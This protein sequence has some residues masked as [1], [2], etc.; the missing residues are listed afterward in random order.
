MQFVYS[1]S[2]HAKRSAFSAFVKMYDVLYRVYMRLVSYASPVTNSTTFF[3]ATFRCNSRDFIQ[4]RIRFF[5]VYEHNLSF[6]MISRLHAGGVLID[7]GANAGYFSVLGSKLVGEQGKVISV[8]ADPNNYSLLN[9]NLRLNNCENVEAMNVAATEDRCVV[10]IRSMDAFNS[11]RS[12]IVLQ[13]LE[14]AIGTPGLPFSD[15]VKTE[16]SRIN[17]IKVDIE[18]SEGPVL[19]QIL[20]LLNEMPN[21]LIVATEVSP[22]S[23]WCI[24]AF[25]RA[26]FRA[27][28]ISNNYKID[29]YLIRR[30]LAYCGE[31]RFISVMPVADYS[32]RHTDYVFERSLPERRSRRPTRKAGTLKLD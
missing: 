31:H 19:K 5:G 22:S 7:I 29:Y 27:F 15:I 4:R 14:G 13:N 26:G 17:F 3:G 18:G 10:S 21:D 23:A 12:T 25:K 20:D 2:E 6:Y 11:G 8:E 1:R 16:L 30:H 32:P 28:A 9:E 24:D